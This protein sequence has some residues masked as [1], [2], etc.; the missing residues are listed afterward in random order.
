MSFGLFLTG[1]M[2]LMVGLAIGANLLHV[3]A[4]WI[5]VGVI[6]MAGFGILLGV[7]TTRHRDPSD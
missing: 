6:V 3:P 1:F 2:V 4:Q 7:T 5:G